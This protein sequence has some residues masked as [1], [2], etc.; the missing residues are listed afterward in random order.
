MLKNYFKTALRNILRQK[1]STFINV[2]GLTLGITCSLVLFLMVRHMSTFDAYHTNRD[3]IYRVVTESDGNSGRFYTPGVPSVLPEAFKEDFHEAEEVTFLSYRS[4]AMVTIPEDGQMPRKFKE[5]AGVVFGQPNFFKIFDRKILSG[6]AEKGL[7]DPGEAIISESLAKKYFPNEEAIGKVVKF[8]TVEYKITAVMEDHPL[9][10]DFPFTLMLSYITIKKSGDAS[11]WGSIWSD[12]Q[13]YVL[14]KDQAAAQAIA[15]RMPAF[16]E[17]HLG[18][19]NY[20]KQTWTLQPLSE[21]H[22]D[23]R[24][25]TFTYSTAPKAT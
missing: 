4:G 15:S 13:C 18:S 7:D 23:D 12:E 14:L 21:I 20:E 11:K 25:G 5:D 19:N 22:F 8:D 17:K 24:Y 9:T 1:A 2:S 6:S 3:R 16:V 10:T